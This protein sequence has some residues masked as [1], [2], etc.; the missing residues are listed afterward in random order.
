MMLI[1][2]IAGLV[3]LFGGATGLPIVVQIQ[4]RVPVVITD[5]A[6]AEVILEKAD[7]M[8]SVA[9]DATEDVV[10]ALEAWSKADKDHSIGRGALKKVLQTSANGRKEARAAFLDELFEIKSKM[11][12]EQWK[13]VFEETEGDAE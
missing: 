7:V 11:T 5:E 10:E 2:I 1:A 4:E 13:A 3:M 8:A 12:K 6:K 9:E